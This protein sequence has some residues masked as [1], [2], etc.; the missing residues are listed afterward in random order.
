MG[1]DLEL[2]YKLKTEQKRIEEELRSFTEDKEIEYEPIDTMK[3]IEDIQQHENNMEEM[4]MDKNKKKKIKLVL[5][6]EFDGNDMNEEQ[7]RKDI[8]MK[9][10]EN[11]EEEE[12]QD[13]KILNAMSKEERLQF[14]NMQI[15]NP[16]DL[17]KNDPL[18]ISAKLKK[19]KTHKNN[20]KK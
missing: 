10:N 19:C 16:F 5:R 15:V 6:H 12:D 8:E 9:E 4:E 1:D 11:M 13:Q 17:E 14:D 7:Y 2:E 18:L 3:K 20:M